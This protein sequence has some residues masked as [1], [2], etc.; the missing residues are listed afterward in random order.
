MKRK[1]IQKCPACISNVGC[2]G[3][4][5][6]APDGIAAKLAASRRMK[7]ISHGDPDRERPWSEVEAARAAGTRASE[8]GLTEAD[9]PHGPEY[10]HDCFERCLSHEWRNAW[11]TR[12]YDSDRPP[13]RYAQ[14]GLPGL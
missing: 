13:P 5:A 1:E 9:C 4:C 10:D 7:G 11:R 6:R 8:A 2:F 14:P 12:H 3:T